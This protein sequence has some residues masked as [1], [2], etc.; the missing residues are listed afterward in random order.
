VAGLIGYLAVV[1]VFAAVNALAGRSPLYTAALLGGALVSGLRDPAAVVI[2]AGPILAYNAL[3]LLVF[4][5][6]GL[7]AAWLAYWGERG[8]AF[9]YLGLVLFILVLFHLFAATQL[10]TGPLRTALPPGQVWGA[11][12]GAALAMTAYLLAVHPDL[13]G[14]LTG[15]VE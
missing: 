15:P 1:I 10:F 6:V 14:R 8:P 4:L 9:W 2:A 11:G 3:H 12:L 13:R 5:G 7:L